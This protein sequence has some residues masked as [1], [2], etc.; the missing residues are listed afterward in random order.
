M[1]LFQRGSLKRRLIWQLLA[2]QYAILTALTAYIVMQLIRADLGGQYMDT[3]AIE[4][5]GRSIQ[6]LP[7]GRLSLT[8]T[9]DLRKLK[10]DA[11]NIWFVARSA[12][13]ELLSEGR[14]PE[15]YRSLIGAL[16]RI[17]F[18]DIRD[19]APPYDLSAAVRST[20]TAAGPFTII[21][22]N[23]EMV[24]MTFVIVLLSQLLMIPI[25]LLLALIALIAI[26][27][28]V[29]RAFSGLATVA[30]HAREI[31]VDRRGTRLSVDRIPAEVG[32]LVHAINGALHRLDE[33]Y[34]QHQRFL[35]DAAHELRTPIAILQTRLEILEPGPIRTRLMLDA[36]R[37]AAL[38][39]QLL[40][41]QRL[42]RTNDNFSDVDLGEL[43]QRVAADLAPLAIATGYELSL[44]IQQHEATVTG[45]PGAL[46]RAITNLVQNAI[47][48]AGRRGT[49]T[50]RVARGGVIEVADDG[51]GIPDTER[52]NIFAPF[53]RL[54]PQDRGAGLGLNLVR[55][56]VRRHGGDISVTTPAQGGACFRIVLPEAPKPAAL[57]GQT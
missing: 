19:A 15:A 14:M 43:C 13:G 49:I 4:V 52:E 27:I 33:G 3:D 30:A 45:D 47:E 48:H 7:D 42:E 17:S 44:D 9:A 36:S 11:P 12:S 24:G 34:E 35:S 16:G 41:M 55:N 29:S 2:L 21:A 18:S 10:Q 40:D 26:P 51:P 22:G 39:E 28:I 46:G 20:D 23:G 54:Q 57:G 37:V 1:K 6:R 53:Y 56:I 50:I 31:D 38:A 5:I 25:L 32:P 8:D